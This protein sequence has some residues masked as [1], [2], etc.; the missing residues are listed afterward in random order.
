MKWMALY[1]FFSGTVFAL[2]EEEL[3]QSILK[4]FPLIEEASLKAK[5]STAEV[6][7]SKGAFDHK[8]TFKSRNRIE[9]KYENQFIETTLERQTALGGLGLVVGHRQGI[10]V[11]PAYDGK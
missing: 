5:A 2:S 6:E 1:L 7:A 4:N 11:F 10:G 9:D 8:L 3:T